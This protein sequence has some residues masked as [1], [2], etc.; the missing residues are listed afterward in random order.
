VAFL[1]LQS[2]NPM[3]IWTDRAGL[4]SLVLARTGLVVLI[5]MG[6]FFRFNGLNWDN[7]R[8]LHPDERFLSTV[9][10]DLTWPE[11]FSHYFDPKVSTLSPYSLQNMGLFV[12]GTFPIYLV[13]FISVQLDRNTYDLIPLTGRA[14]SALFDLGA[15]AFLFLIGRKLYGSQIALL[16][17]ALLSLSVLNIQLSHFYTVDTFAN[18]FVMATFY[19]LLR[20]AAHGR[21]HDYAL[22]GLVFGLGMASKISIFTL[23]APIVLAAGLDFA[24]RYRSGDDVRE[25]AEQVLVRMA[26]LVAV[27][28]LTFRVFQ[29]VAFAGPSFLN[30]TL[31]PEWLE[32]IAEQARILSGNVNLPWMQQWVD[33]PVSF[34]FYNLL[35]WGLGLPLGLAGLAGLGLAAY[36]LVRQRRVEHLLPVVYVLFTFS[37]LAVQFVKFMRYFLPI[38]PFL[39]LLAAYLLVKVWNRAIESHPSDPSAGNHFR[40]MNRARAVL[41]QEGT[42]KALVAGLITIVVGGTLLY[43]L[44]FSSLYTRPHSR[45]QASRWMYANLPPG[46]AIANEHW[47]DWLPIG[48]VDG[49]TAY[50]DRGLFT[51]IEMKNYDPD[52]PEKLDKIIDNL[53][54]A[55]YLVLSSNRLYD[56]IP[57]QPLRYPLGSRY[58][59]LLFNGGLGFEPLIEFTSFP[60]LFGIRLVD[61]VAE[62]SF[63]VYDHPRVQIFKKSADF[64][65]ELVRSR[66]SAG[67][68][69][70]VVHNIT[71]RQ[72]TLA[73][74]GLRFTTEQLQLYQRVSEWSSAYIRPGSWGSHLPVL[75]WGLMLQVIALLALPLVLVAFRTL[76]DRGYIFSKGVGLLVVAWG[77]W[78]AASLRIA[79]FT[80]WQIW[81]VMVL[82]GLVSAWVFYRNR[83]ELVSFIRLRWRLLLFQEGLFWGLFALA[84]V[85]RWSNP[86][87]WHPFMGG[88]KPMD[89]AYL[90]AIIKTPFFPPYDPWYAGGYIN[91]YYFGFV[92]VA[93]LIHLTGIVPYVAYNLAVPTFFAMTGMG[94]FA[95]AFNLVARE[96]ER[97]LISI[98]SSAVLAGLCGV[99][100]TLLIGNLG[101]IRLLFDGIRNLSE[102]QAG[103]DASPF[104][105]LAQFGDGFMQL[106]DGKQLSM[107]TE[108]WY[109][110]ATRVIPPGQGEAGPIN[111]M[112]L[113]TFLFGDL[114]AHMM[115]LP[116]TLLA[117]GLSL[118]FLRRA[119]SAE[120]GKSLQRLLSSEAFGLFFLALTIGALWATNTW[121]LPTYTAL[122][123]A[124]LVWRE[125]SLRKKIDVTMVWSAVWRIGLVLVS[126]RLLFAPFHSAFARS[127][128]GFQLWTGSRTPLWNYIEIHGFF[129]FLIVSYLAAELIGGQKHNPAVRSLRLFITHMFYFRRL[130][131]LFGVLVRPS[132]WYKLSIQTG[133]AGFLL[134]FG[135]FLVNRQ[136]GLVLG[137]V[138]LCLGLLLSSPSPHRQFILSMTGLALTLTLIVEFVVLK[139][140][141][142]RMNTVFKFYLQ[143]WVLLALVS[144]A[145]FPSLVAR[146]RQA[147]AARRK[148]FMG[149][150]PRDWWVIFAVLL[151]ATLLYPLT[152]VPVRVR[153]RFPESTSTTLDGSTFMRSAIYNDQGQ[154][155][156]LDW[157]RQAVE[158]LR[159]NVRGLPT[160]VEANTPLYR[161]GGRVS[162]YTGL[163]AL[164]GWDWHQKQQRSALPGEFIDRRLQD[165]KEFYSTT[166]HNR[167]HELLDR[168][169]VQYIYVGP[170]ER[171][172]YPA[173]GIAK[174]T[175]QKGQLWDLVYENEQ[176]QI[177]QVR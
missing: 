158:W 55:D 20:A 176:V 142:S 46:S 31:N 58:Y 116:Y 119:W 167:A 67:L 149:W 71:P 172:H 87:L 50:G 28:A 143:T 39:A 24:R 91:Y 166:D 107:R 7:G 156:S 80:R 47:D 77:A 42:L 1:K 157:D 134:V 19:F 133:I 54:K 150:A 131:R 154:M 94:A 8:N 102:L 25:A 163:P 118:S 69:W 95:V 16:G 146:V 125:Y 165:V 160:I 18:L 106:L 115:A 171:V 135:V 85:V 110:N 75:A 4:N 12:Y 169:D 153:D 122:A 76:S 127:S 96:D 147:A 130:R 51:G 52:T 26:T 53:D 103:S 72:S 159:E 123:L 14:L 33:R 132:A 49:L 145:V 144:A 74:N 175:A 45:V 151:T 99:F 36:E 81:G 43:A 78:L 32:D 111:E 117:L 35:V 124:A 65:P 105:M 84:L 44:A 88:E 97:Q 104:V 40:W 13:K 138:L 5:L 57:R 92:L 15:I 98:R 148:L 64:D 3:K 60:T 79:P 129:L 173:E 101:Q 108:W 30:W 109:W 23:A 68:V 73:G 162:I 61:H 170:V 82:L 9:T 90:T 11:N 114:H 70:P 126:A 29:P 121:D 38:Y 89:L 152:A 10:N 62:E 63:T 139:D 22:T 59:E 41:R 93:A 66:L 128:L 83:Q 177:Y 2:I 137:L 113:F 34:V 48:G 174:F 136:A 37:Y 120:N 21:W 27:T 17:A 141:I 112:P 168:Y 86:D 100:F 140:D 161:W 164:V 155:I 6:V 56:S